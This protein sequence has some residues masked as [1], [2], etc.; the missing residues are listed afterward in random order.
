MGKKLAGQ[1]HSKSFDK[2]LNVQVETSDDLHSSGVSIGTGVIDQLC[3]RHRQ[4]IAPP[5]SSPSCVV[6]LRQWKGCRT[7]GT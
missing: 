3:W 1:S 2:S 5:A 4:G 7:E 6:Q